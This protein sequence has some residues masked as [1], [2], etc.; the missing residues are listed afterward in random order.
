[1]ARARE[2]AGGLQENSPSSMR[3]TKALINGF[4]S[5]D[6]GRQFAD[7]IVQNAQARSTADFREGLTSF[8]EKRK[9][10]WTGN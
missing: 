10:K 2:L 4:I 6:L 7:S 1:M 8:L 5:K 9:P 3:A